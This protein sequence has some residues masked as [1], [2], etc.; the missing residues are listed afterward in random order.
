M[1]ILLPQEPFLVLFPDAFWARSPP[2]SFHA[3]IVGTLRILVQQRPETTAQDRLHSPSRSVS[4][5]GTLEYEPDELTPF[6]GDER[7]AARS[8]LPNLRLARVGRVWSACAHD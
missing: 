4:L 8:H 1:P 5:Q 6:K 3:S 2:L 7:L